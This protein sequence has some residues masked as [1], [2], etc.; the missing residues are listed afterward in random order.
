VRAVLDFG[1]NGRALA[2]HEKVLYMVAAI[3]IVKWSDPCK[4]KVQNVAKR[5]DIGLFTLV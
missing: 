3:F 1:T 5:K 4:K 2:F